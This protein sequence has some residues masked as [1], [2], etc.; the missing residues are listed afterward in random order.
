MVSF[1][2]TPGVQR[3]TRRL[4]HVSELALLGCGHVFA[5]PCGCH[6]RWACSAKQHQETI[7]LWTYLHV[8]MMLLF[9][10]DPD[11]VLRDCV[12]VNSWVQCW[13]TSR[14]SRQKILRPSN[15]EPCSVR[16]AFCASSGVANSAR[17]HPLDRPFAPI[18][19]QKFTVPA[20]RM[21]SCRP[22]PH[23]QQVHGCVDSGIRASGDH[24]S[25]FKSCQLV[26]QL[27]FPTYTRC[28][29]WAAADR[30]PVARGGGS[31]SPASASVAL[32]LP[33]LS[34]TGSAGPAASVMP[35]QSVALHT[36]QPHPSS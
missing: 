28:P 25:T 12:A 31:S 5:A 6:L 26:V 10:I 20:V 35:S 15:S 13:L 7:S 33:G 8:C 17:P 18:T 14:S 27:R 16:I 2:Q 34:S 3:S 9:E 23:H 22:A 24:Y 29:L 11:V 4:A 1:R 30:P 19:L 21:W 32:A 36:L